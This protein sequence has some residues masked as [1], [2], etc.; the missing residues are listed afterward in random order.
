MLIFAVAAAVAA[1]D[2]VSKSFIS[3]HFQLY[4][5][6]PVI[7]RLFHL[8]LVHNRGAAFGIF[9]GGVLFLIIT[10]C[11][12]LVLIVLYVKSRKEP[13]PFILKLALG[14]VMGG[15]IGNLIDRIFLG[16]VVDFLDLRVWPV[17]NA[18]DSAITCGMALLFLY[19]IK[20]GRKAEELKH[21]ARSTKHEA[22]ST[23]H[24]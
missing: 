13:L 3:G 11:L 15:T 22:R 24:E 6:V 4:Q 9:K 23:K 5:S 10:A 1:I 20:N 16:Y 17:F 14:L 12:A 19:F 2:Q 18:A 8:T 7:K 21:E